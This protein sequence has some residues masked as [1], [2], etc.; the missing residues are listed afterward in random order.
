[1]TY[2][3]TATGRQIDLATIKENDICLQDIAHHLTKI[4]RFGGALPFDKHYSVA[5]HSLH[6]V[7]WAKKRKYSKDTLRALLMHDAAEAYLGDVLSPI[8]THLNDYKMWEEKIAKLIQNKY[9]LW[10]TEEILSVITDL[11]KRIL[12]DEVEFFLPTYLNDFLDQNPNTQ[13]LKIT[14]Y[15]EFDADAEML[16]F[17]YDCFLDTCK[18]LEITDY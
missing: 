16:K 6:L 15:N 4:C 8:K 18:F 10:Y 7:A 5:Q 12:I 13:P 11:D 1:M 14:L 2:Y 3:I 17:T 9:R